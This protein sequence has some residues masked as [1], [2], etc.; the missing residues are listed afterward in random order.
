MRLEKIV[1]PDSRSV[2]EK[3]RR[4]FGDEA[5]VI[6]N[7]RSENKN[8]IIVAIEGDGLVDVVDLVKEPLEI[9]QIPDKEVTDTDDQRANITLDILRKELME[10]R[11]EMEKMT[12]KTSPNWLYKPKLSSSHQQILWSELEEIGVPESMRKA[13][14]DAIPSHATPNEVVDHI[15]SVIHNG[16]IKPEIDIS[17][18]KNLLIVGNPGSGKTSMAAR[19]AARVLERDTEGRVAIVSYCD[20]RLGSWSTCQVIANRLGAESYRIQDPKELKKVSEELGHGVMIIDTSGANTKEHITA[21]EEILPNVTVCPV[22]ACDSSES[23]TR[24]I[25]NSVGEEK[26]H[27][28]M[29][30]RMEQNHV[31]WETLGVLLEK[32]MSISSGTFGRDVADHNQV[33]FDTE[34]AKK[35][36]NLVC[37]DFDVEWAINHNQIPM[38][39]TPRASS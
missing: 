16:L 3:I 28:V 6:S 34:L 23:S 33:K 24:E 10:F 29:L 21:I 25:L 17:P 27:S 5:L 26:I 4:S 36:E 37:E 32:G 35:I 38:D 1:G 31:P 11:S 18:G 14:I 7:S 2:I 9:K 12:K 8:E 22:V 20:K 13:W 30:T 19:L 39:M 15:V